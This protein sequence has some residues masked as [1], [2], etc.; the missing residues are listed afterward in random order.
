MATSMAQLDRSAK[1]RLMNFAAIA[2]VTV[3]VIL[4][5]IKGI[6]WLKTGSVAMLASLL[7]SVLDGGAS[8]I[9]LLFVRRAAQPANERY[10]FGH[11][12]AEP[13]GGMFQSIIIGASALF[14][15]A[16]SV[17]RL[18][19]P[20][21][22]TNTGLGIS[23]MVISSLIIGGLVVLQRSVVRKTGSFV[24]SA[25]ALHGMGDVGINLG[26]IA[27][28][29]IA[30]QFDA[31]WIDPVIAMLL[32]GVLLR[33]AWEIGSG[34]VRQLMDVEFSEEEREKIRKIALSHPA[35]RNIHDLRTR[36]A[37]L[38][39]FIQMH[40]ELDRNITLAMAHEIADEV[41]LAVQ[42]EFQEA[43][44]LIHQDPQG[45]E[46]VPAHLRE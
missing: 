2:S 27:A 42:K 44:V 10:R 17:R 3:A 8:T 38:S 43:E 9:N 41:E 21:M 36:R 39:A 28:L 40:I 13:I 24:I 25:D 4:I 7:D 6:A 26:V 30:T 5:V 16:E 35:V 34:A 45:L 15:I 32:A 18:L 23:I 11:G 14:L 33:G 20:T 29:L 31:A 46:P 1:E 19:E 22:P 12:K 37:G